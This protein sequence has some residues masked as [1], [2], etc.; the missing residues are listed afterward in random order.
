M[1]YRDESQATGEMRWVDRVTYDGTWENLFTILMVTMMAMVGG[2]PNRTCAASFIEWNENSTSQDGYIKT[3]EEYLTS[4][5]QGE[6]RF[7]EG[8]TVIHSVKRIGAQKRIELEYIAIMVDERVDS[9]SIEAQYT[10]SFPFCIISD[11]NGELKQL[12][13]GIDEGEYVEYVEAKS[14]DAFTDLSAIGNVRKNAAYSVYSN[15]DV[16]FYRFN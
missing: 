13:R 8:R 1:D 9:D 16:T 7:Y 5:Y 11:I 10:T 2:L 15:Q 14:S 4:Y 12:Y 6:Y 3:I